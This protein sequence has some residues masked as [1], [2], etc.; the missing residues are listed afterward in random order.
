MNFNQIEQAYDDRRL[1]DHIDHI[2]E[3]CDNCALREECEA[4]EH[5]TVC[6]YWEMERE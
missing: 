3:S 1:S 5:V 4:K 6:D 2:E